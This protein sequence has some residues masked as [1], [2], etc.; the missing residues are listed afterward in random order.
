M[1]RIWCGRWDWKESTLMSK[2][3]Y[4]PQ[5]TRWIF[6]PF[7]PYAEEKAITCKKYL[8]L[9]QVADLAWKLSGLLESFHVSNLRITGFVYCFDYYTD[10]IFFA[11]ARINLRL[12]DC[13]W[14]GIVVYLQCVK[15]AINYT[16][17]GFN[18]GR[19]VRPASIPGCQPGN[20]TSN[21]SSQWL[22]SHHSLWWK[23]LSCSLPLNF[24]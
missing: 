18:R 1:S 7:S 23:V 3:V 8:L 13:V 12:G 16:L 19:V 9:R 21:P 5:S 15:H 17:T 10:I 20:W 6:L 24:L 2:L 4:Q 11:V 22:W 14:R